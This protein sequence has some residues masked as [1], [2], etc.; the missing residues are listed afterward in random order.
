MKLTLD[1]NYLR[2][3]A[4]LSG[5]RRDRRVLNISAGFP[6]LDRSCWDARGQQQVGGGQ[7]SPSRGSC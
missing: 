2:K 5:G 6:V 1:V 7:C 3:E 4:Y